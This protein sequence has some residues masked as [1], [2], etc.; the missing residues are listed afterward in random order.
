MPPRL[1]TSCSALDVPTPEASALPPVQ[2]CAG[3]F[4]AAVVSPEGAATPAAR[5]SR[6][7]GPRL[8]G[9][10]PTVKILL[11]VGLSGAAEQA[12]QPHPLLRPET[13]TVVAVGLHLVTNAGRVVALLEINRAEKYIP[14]WQ[15]DA[16]VMPTENGLFV[17][18]ALMPNANA[19]V[20]PVKARAHPQ[21][22]TNAA[23]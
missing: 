12:F 18:Q 22:L 13:P 23:E 8:N 17:F 9:V 21:V 6:F 20:H 5:Q 4:G 3:R 7:R 14:P 10:G 19:V 2:T 16:K 1:L 11:I 15:Q